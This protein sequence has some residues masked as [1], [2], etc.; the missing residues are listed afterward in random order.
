MKFFKLA[1]DVAMSHPEILVGAG[2][3][4]ALGASAHMLSQGKA[5]YQVGPRELSK[6]TQQTT[7]GNHLPKTIC[8]K[9]R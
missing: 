3:V 2:V 6:A 8:F 9:P 4:G 1:F 5:S 7:S